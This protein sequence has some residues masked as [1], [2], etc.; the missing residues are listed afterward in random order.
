MFTV[1]IAGQ[2]LRRPAMMVAVGNA[3]SYGGGMHITPDASIDDGQLDVCLVGALSRTRFAAAFP[4]V[5]AGTHVRHP[6]VTMLRGTVVEVEADRPFRVYA[7]GEPMGYVPVR[8][9]VEPL[10]LE[11]VAP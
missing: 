1:R 3:P 9:E 6:A 11:V 4:K 5:F 8:Y 2:Q 7:D 10:A